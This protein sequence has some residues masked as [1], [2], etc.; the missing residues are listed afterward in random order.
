M[1]AGAKVPDSTAIVLYHFNDVWLSNCAHYRIVY[2]KRVEQMYMLR[3]ICIFEADCYERLWFIH[4]PY[5]AL[6]LFY[7]VWTQGLL[8]S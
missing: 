7:G 6:P 1:P 4:A 2:Y 8:H 3:G 5:V